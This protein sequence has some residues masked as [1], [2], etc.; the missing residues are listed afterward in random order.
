MDTTYHVTIVANDGTEIGRYSPVTLAQGRRM[1]D[2]YAE[3]PPHDKSPTGMVGRI[4]LSTGEGFS[5]DFIDSYVPEDLAFCD[6]CHEEFWVKDNAT[7]E[8]H[9]Y[10]CPVCAAGDTP[11]SVPVTME[12]VMVIMANVKIPPPNHTVTDMAEQAER[13]AA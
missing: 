2:H 3:H 12:Q 9:A 6:D 5:E 10:Q 7:T 1:L 8:E 4:Q 13:A 11:E